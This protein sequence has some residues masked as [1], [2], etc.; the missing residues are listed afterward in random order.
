VARGDCETAFAEAAAADGILLSKQS[1]PWISRRGHLVLTESRAVIARDALLAIFQALGGVTAELE[2]A[3]AARLPGDF[4][5]EPTGTLIEVDER[6]HFTS[7]RLLTLRLYPPEIPLGFDRAE[8]E[9]LCRRL[10][11]QANR[12]FAHRSAPAFGPGGRQ[13]QRA[14]FDSLRDL[15]AP[16]MGHPPVIRI[17]APHR[18]GTAAYKQHRD[19]IL[20]ALRA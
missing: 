8:Y 3:A 18:N 19:Q 6:Q 17:Q 7:A 1:L 9:A 10:Q 4:L 13:Q 11:G 15:A 20:T 5:H 12:D 2:A 14:Y 16:V